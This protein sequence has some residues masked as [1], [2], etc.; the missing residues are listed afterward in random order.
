MDTRVILLCGEGV[1]RD[2]YQ[3]A[4]RRLGVQLDTVS[5]LKALYDAMGRTPYNGVL[6]DIL[7]KIKAPQDEKVLLHAV[8]E[9]FPLVQLKWDGEA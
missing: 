2:Q 9:E 4:I 6:I 8:L 3:A 5:S 7:T 1:A